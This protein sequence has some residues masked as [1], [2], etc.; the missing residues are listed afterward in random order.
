METSLQF[1][2]A[3]GSDTSEVAAR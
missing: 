2:S 3:N 1:M